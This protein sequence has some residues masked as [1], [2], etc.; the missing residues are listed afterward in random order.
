MFNTISDPFVIGAL[1][2]GTISL[3]LAMVVGLSV[4]FLRMALRHAQR[5]E[6]RTV[7]KWRPVFNA[8]LTEDTNISLPTLAHREEVDFL[9]LLVYFQT[10]LRGEANQALDRIGY[11]LHCDTIAMRLL[12]R[13]NRAEQLLAILV[14]GHLKV[15]PA[16]S[17]LQQHAIEK[18]SV[19]SPHAYWA[20]AQIDP[21]VIAAMARDFLIRTD[22]PLSQVA[23]TLKDVPDSAA[24]LSTMLEDTT[25]D[26]APRI[27]RLAEALH[28]TIPSER[29]RELLSRASIDVVTA[30]LRLV[31]NP[32][33]LPEIRAFLSH[34]NW[35]VR[36]HAARALGKI[37]NRDDFD[38]LLPLL[39]DHEW[40]VRYRTAQA[41][42]DMPFIGRAEIERLKT[43]T[44]RYARDIVQHVLAER[45]MP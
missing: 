24:L 10:S 2:G 7:E 1:W 45:G 11:Q 23:N 41:M 28:V 6:R 33:L 44:D 21:S 17:L 9:K 42:I 22:L 37:G 35:Q 5:R 19:K 27:L 31:S 8:I 30:T 12:E 26:E 15:K 38:R 16:V 20:I 34:E 40:W 32:A 36:L 18:D 43:H 13:G 25:S 3:S 4:I 14:L 29:I 39:E